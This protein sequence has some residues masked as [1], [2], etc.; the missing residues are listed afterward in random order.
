MAGT[1]DGDFVTGDSVS[2][3]SEVSDVEVLCTMVYDTHGGLILLF[4][5]QNEK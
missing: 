2:F 3:G 1:F 5:P 4:D